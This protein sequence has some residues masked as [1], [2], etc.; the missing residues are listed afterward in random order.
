MADESRFN[1][2]QQ[3]RQE[4]QVQQQLFL[5]PQTENLGELHRLVKKLVGQLE[6]NKIQKE[7]IVRNV[8][9]LSSQLQKAGA[10]DGDIAIFNVFLNERK[11]E[12]KYL[13]HT[14]D[15]ADNDDLIRLRSQNN[16]LKKLLVMNTSK[17]NDTF[18]LLNYHT[19]AFNV[20][21]NKLRQDI[22]TN[23][24]GSLVKIKTKFNE[25]VATLED[26]EFKSYI[27]N[28]QEFDKLKDL[29]ELYKLLLKSLDCQ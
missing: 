6:E 20:V 25:E 7:I 3:L 28:I 9:S 10:S 5:S 14:Q 19:E 22:I 12:N 23:R 29:L 24:N 21:V 18:R 13:P 1:N 27:N 2:Q 8:D 17:L 15:T 26:E 4:Q 16:S 11:I